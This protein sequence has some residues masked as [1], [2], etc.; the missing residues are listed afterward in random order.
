M[1]DRHPFRA[2]LARAAAACTFIVAVL[3]TLGFPGCPDSDFRPGTSSNPHAIAMAN[4]W[5]N[6]DGRWW[7]Y[8]AELRGLQGEDWSALPPGVTPM[9]VTAA[10]ARRLFGDPVDYTDVTDQYDYRLQFN[11]TI[12]TQSGVT[13]QNLEA[14]VG[15]PRGA[16][17]ATGGDAFRAALLSRI[18]AARPDLR[19]RLA[20]RGVRPAIAEAVPISP[21]FIHGHAWRKAPTWIGTYG[22]LDTFPAWKFLD[23]DLREGKSF[24]VQLV[25]ELADDIWLRVLVGDHVAALL[26]DGRTETGLRVWYLIDFGVSQQTNESGQVVGTY[27]QFDYGQVIWVP[28]VGPVR[29]VER[30]FAVATNTLTHG[31]LDLRLTLAE[32]GFGGIAAAR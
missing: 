28:A 23:S 11:G 13:A 20:A 22:D 16:T 29:D 32:T 10:D 2:R 21:Y 19:A 31:M 30:R 9:G 3:G 24:E 27:R 18:A 4:L 26:P 5:P 6:D 1:S 17:G 7:R 8:T 25:R 15:Y 12:T 14:T